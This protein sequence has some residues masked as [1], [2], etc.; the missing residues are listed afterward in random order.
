MDKFLNEPRMWVLALIIMFLVWTILQAVF[1]KRNILRDLKRLKKLE[2]ITDPLTMQRIYYLGQK[3]GYEEVYTTLMLER[4]KDKQ[5]SHD[6]LSV[7]NENA[8]SSKKLKK[9]T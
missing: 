6:S 8:K 4:L 5:H 7:F 3:Y 2:E 1:L 9:R